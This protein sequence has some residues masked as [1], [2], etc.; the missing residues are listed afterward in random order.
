VLL[1]EIV[2]NEVVGVLDGEMVGLVLGE[3]VGNAVVGVL[4]G[5]IVG[6]L[7]G[8]IVGKEGIQTREFFMDLV[9]RKDKLPVMTLCLADER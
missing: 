8:E 6:V 7:L 2:G 5:E 1:G 4:D 3:I 9:E